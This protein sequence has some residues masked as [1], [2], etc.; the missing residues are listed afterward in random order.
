MSAPSA[1]PAKGRPAPVL[2]LCR[3]CV[4]YVFEGTEICPHCGRD[5]R[6]IGARYRDGR[7]QAIEAIQR[8]EHVLQRREG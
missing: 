4:E 6:E 2:M 7:Y 3:Q 8:I 1:P 5:A